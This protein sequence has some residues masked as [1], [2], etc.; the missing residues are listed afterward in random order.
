MSTSY[1]SAV[2]ALEKIYQK[3]YRIEA[4]TTLLQGIEHGEIKDLENSSV[5]FTTLASET[6]SGAIS[7]I[8]DACDEIEEHLQVTGGKLFKDLRADAES[9]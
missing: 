3:L 7:G 5:T 6:L 8:F 2:V 1:H 4:A 9:E